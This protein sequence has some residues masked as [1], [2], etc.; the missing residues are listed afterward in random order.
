MVGM[1][2]FSDKEKRKLRRQF[3]RDRIAKDL[4]SPKYR[5]RVKERKRYDDDEGYYFRDV[6]YDEED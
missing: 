4:H 2:K 3:E 5:Q 1:N 6:Y